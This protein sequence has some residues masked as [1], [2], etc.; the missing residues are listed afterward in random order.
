MIKLKKMFINHQL[1]ALS[2][3]WIADKCAPAELLNHWHYFD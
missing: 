2:M 3:C 1:V